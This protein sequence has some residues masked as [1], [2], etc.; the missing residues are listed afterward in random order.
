MGKL[1][2]PGTAVLAIVLAACS[3]LTVENYDQ[4]KVGMT[5][6]E[7]R[8]LLGAPTQCDDVLTLRSCTWEDG[9]RHVQVS[10]VGERVVLFNS[11]NLR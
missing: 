3:K 4:L 9:E 2:L 6:A 5:Y 8:Q 7:V 1:A 10:F 11:S